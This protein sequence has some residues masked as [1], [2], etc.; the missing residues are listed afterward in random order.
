MT[1]LGDN[2]AE[3]AKTE[4]VSI[5]NDIIEIPSHNYI[6]RAASDNTRKAYQ[7]DIRHFMAWGWLIYVISPCFRLASLAHLDEAN[8]SLLNLM[9]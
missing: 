2:I 1:L 6:H 5:Q 7:A 8:W 3:D 9:I 4:L